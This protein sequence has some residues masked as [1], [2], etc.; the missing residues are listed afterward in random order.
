MADGT[1]ERK[2]AEIGPMHPLGVSFDVT[3]DGKLLWTEFREGRQEL[4]IAETGG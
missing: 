3:A 1:D 2:L 4:W